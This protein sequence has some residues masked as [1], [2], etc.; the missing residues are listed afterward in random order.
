[1]SVIFVYVS[2]WALDV[3]ARTRLLELREKS[4]R[5]EN[6]SRALNTVQAREAEQRVT[7]QR[8]RRESHLAQVD[9][10]GCG[11]QSLFDNRFEVSHVRD[12]FEGCSLDAGRETAFHSYI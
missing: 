11:E 9:L 5:A 3:R 12:S 6:G 7:T 2:S 8:K 1:M 10:S 4:L